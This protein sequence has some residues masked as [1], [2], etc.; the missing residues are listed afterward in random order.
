MK[1]DF[2][3]HTKSVKQGETEKRNIDSKRF[4]EK[5]NDANVKI[6]AITNHNDFDKKQYEEFV[7]E[8][9]ES[10]QIWPGIELDIKDDETEAHLIIISNPN[11]LNQFETSINNLI[12]DN[13][14]STFIAN[15]EDVL[16]ELSQNFDM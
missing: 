14:K 1:I 15:I 10:F 3:C 5:I 4:V 7:E 12:G 9:N 6:V 8:A 2:H 13:D 11:C 16:N